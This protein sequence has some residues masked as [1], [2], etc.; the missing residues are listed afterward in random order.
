MGGQASWLLPAAAIVLVGGLAWR[1]R[2]PRTDRLRA[3]LML[4]GS[5]LVVSGA[6]FSF[7]SGVIHTYYTVEL[8][9]A[10]AALAG[11]GAAV[12]WQRRRACGR[13]HRHG[14]DGRRH[15]RRGRS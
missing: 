13:P 5:W 3:A 8:A 4:W 10:I 12:L 6:V 14:V 15:R 1:M 9:P 2:A 7:S 11:I